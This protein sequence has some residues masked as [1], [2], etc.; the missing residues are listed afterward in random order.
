MNDNIY[1]VKRKVGDAYVTCTGKV[2]GKVKRRKAKAYK[3]PGK[4][5]V[6]SCG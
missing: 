2:I 1:C 5:V 3:R 4:C 6:K